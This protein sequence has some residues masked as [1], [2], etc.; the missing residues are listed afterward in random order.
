MY[1][2]NYHLLYVHLKYN[3][4]YIHHETDILST[5]HTYVLN[6]SCKCNDKE[7]LEFPVVDNSYYKEQLLV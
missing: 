2:Y 7:L 3:I 1:L 5:L 6:Q 4:Y